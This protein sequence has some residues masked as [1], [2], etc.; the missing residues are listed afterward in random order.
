[1]PRR[2]V[3][4]LCLSLIAYAKVPRPLADVPIHTQDPKKNIRLKSYRGKVLMVI[5]FLTDCQDCVK[6]INFAAKLQADFGPRGF[7]AIGAAVDD[8]APYL[9]GP[10]SQ[11][12]RPGFPIGYL[13]K[14]TEIVH[15]LDFAPDASPSAPIMVFIDHTGTVR[16]QYTERDTA[17]FGPEN[18][19]LRLIVENLL[20]QRDAHKAPDRVTAPAK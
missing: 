10:F 16:F 12:Y 11:R 6:M 13:N 18:R 7:Q 19:Y 3:A 17:I 20:R 9:I 1:M 15:L 4:L 2:L 8:N 14:Q 5:L